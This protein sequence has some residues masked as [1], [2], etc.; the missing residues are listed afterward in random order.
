MFQ[1]Y[2]PRP[3][4]RRTS[5]SS[6]A[7]CLRCLAP[8]LL[9]LHASLSMKNTATHKPVMNITRESLAANKHRNAKI[10]GKQNNPHPL[11]S[12]P[13]PPLPLPPSRTPSP[14]PRTP[15]PVSTSHAP[16]NSDYTN[17]SNVSRLPVSWCKVRRLHHNAIQPSQCHTSIASAWAHVNGSEHRKH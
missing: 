15:A 10:K 2:R 1:T 3:G 12:S 11:P 7:T 9:S 16:R 6:T 14:P 8:P 13:P 17:R 5:G 4:G